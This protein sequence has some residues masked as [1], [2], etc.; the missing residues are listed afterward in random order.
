MCVC[1][2]DCPCV[3]SVITL[4]GQ[5]CSQ[6]PPPIPLSRPS[7]PAINSFPMLLSLCPGALVALGPLCPHGGLSPLQRE[8]GWGSCASLSPGACCGQAGTLL[9]GSVGTP[10][11]P[12]RCRGGFSPVPTHGMAADIVQVPWVHGAATGYENQQQNPNFLEACKKQSHPP[13]PSPLKPIPRTLLGAENATVKR[14]KL[15]QGTSSAQRR[16][17]EF[18]R[19]FRKGA[20]VLQL[21]G[22]VVHC[23]R[24]R[25]RC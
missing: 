5:T 16:E 15:F 14:E 23:S 18:G 19:C 20:F 3:P 24:V 9:G 21:P 8:A 4:Q 22:W 11:S 17:R 13:A 2:C 25:K 12:S 10:Q 1:V 6:D 7:S